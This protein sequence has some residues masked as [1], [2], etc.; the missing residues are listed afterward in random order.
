MRN[1]KA[2]AVK[3]TSTIGFLTPHS[4]IRPLLQLIII[5]LID[6]SA[7][8]N[9]AQTPLLHQVE[10]VAVFRENPTHFKITTTAPYPR[11]CLS[12]VK[13]VNRV[14]IMYIHL[15]T[16]LRKPSSLSLIGFVTSPSFQLGCFSFFEKRLFLTQKIIR[17]LSQLNFHCNFHDGPARR[18]HRLWLPIGSGWS[19]KWSNDLQ[20]LQF[21]HQRCLVLCE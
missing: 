4:T 20:H 13:L 7:G 1:R 9:H 19:A 16:L 11:A 5:V 2:I 10:N 14:P 21:Y 8:L 12:T 17:T 15:I 3:M 6:Q 18:S